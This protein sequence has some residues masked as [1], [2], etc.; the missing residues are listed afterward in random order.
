[1]Q[2]LF[3]RTSLDYFLVFHFGWRVQPTYAGEEEEEELEVG[4]RRHCLDFWA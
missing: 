2:A 3:K 1:M 4:Y